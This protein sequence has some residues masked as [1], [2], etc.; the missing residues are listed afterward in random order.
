MK[1]A[2]QF[3]FLTGIIIGWS[4]MTLP[5]VH[6]QA[7]RWELVYY[8]NGP[9][10][11]PGFQAPWDTNGVEDPEL[12]W[13]GMEFRLYYTAIDALGVQRIAAATS[14]NLLEWTPRGIILEPRAGT[15]D[16]DG[17]SDPDV[18]R[19]GS[20]Y[21]LF[22]T[23]TNY[24]WRQIAR[25]DSPDGY[26]F[27]GNRDV[28]LTGSFNGN[29]FDYLG[30]GE[31]SVIYSGGMYQLVYRG[32]DS[33]VWWRLGLALSEDGFHFLSISSSLERQAIFGR[34]P[35]GYDD[36]GAGEPE[37]WSG[38]ANDIR[39]LYTSLHYC[40]DGPLYRIGYTSDG[41]FNWDRYNMIS[42]I[43]EPG[44]WNGMHFKSPSVLDFGDFLLVAMEGWPN[45]LQASGIGLMIGVERW[46]KSKQN[47]LVFH[48]TGGIVPPGR[49]EL[50]NYGA[51]D[52]VITGITVI[53]PSFTIVPPSLPHVLKPSDERVLSVS[54]TPDPGGTPVQ[55]RVIIESNAQIGNT[56]TIHLSGY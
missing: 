33:N 34:G 52:V 48:T 51:S 49:I 5:S 19:V 17:V 36:G 54:Y 2:H 29:R 13:D 53:G 6:A 9:V 1:T 47:H 28:V 10:I 11:T 8:P 12:L 7:P 50:G 46:L 38:N 45:R 14:R 31:P 56:I 35:H 40:L 37:I 22:Y 24:E 26:H 4:M 42:G 39:M 23:A 18:L 44:D 41:Y 16:R 21:I 27:T 43:G 25:V 15:F 55:G 30:A 20:Q 3:I 32:F